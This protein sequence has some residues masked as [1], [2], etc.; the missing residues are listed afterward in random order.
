MNILEKLQPISKE[1]EQVNNI[2]KGRGIGTGLA[3]DMK[4][5]MEAILPPE[6][7]YEFH[8]NMSGEVAHILYEKNNPNNFLKL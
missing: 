8:F 2:N 1:I 6:I 4:M 7:G 3:D 5:G